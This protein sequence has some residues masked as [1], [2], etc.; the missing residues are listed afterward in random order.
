MIAHGPG[1]LRVKKPSEAPEPKIAA[2]PGSRRALSCRFLRPEAANCAAEPSP[3]PEFAF[4]VQLMFSSTRLGRS[5]QPVR[6][7]GSETPRD[8]P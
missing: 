3:A 2:E 4:A 7:A 5:R 8:P 1:S 6:G